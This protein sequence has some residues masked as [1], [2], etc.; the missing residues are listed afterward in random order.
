M[1]ALDCM[2]R[3]NSIISKQSLRRQMITISMSLSILIR[4]FGADSQ[5]VTELPIGHSI[6]W[7]LIRSSLPRRVRL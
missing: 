2:T 4:M 1:P 7:V 3:I 6:K 5:V